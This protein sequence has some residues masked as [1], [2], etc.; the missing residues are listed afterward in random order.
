MLVRQARLSRYT[1]VPLFYRSGVPC[2]FP[3]DV[4][5]YTHF[6]TTVQATNN[7]LGSDLMVVHNEFVWV[8]TRSKLWSSSL[9]VFKLKLDFLSGG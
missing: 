8:L 4:D 7:H 6:N 1:P 5:I 9:F 2:L 3:K